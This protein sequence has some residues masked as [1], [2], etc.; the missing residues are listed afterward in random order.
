M[1]Q[2]GSGQ[3]WYLELLKLSKQ[4][5]FLIFRK[6]C[7]ERKSIKS[8]SSINTEQGSNISRVDYYRSQLRHTGILEQASPTNLKLEKG[9]LFI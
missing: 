4:L 1:C 9:G 3:Y 2:H 8:G 7:L 5:S 6:I